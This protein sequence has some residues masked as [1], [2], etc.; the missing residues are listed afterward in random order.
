VLRWLLIGTILSTYCITSSYLSYRETGSPSHDKVSG[1]NNAM[2]VT[3]PAALM[4]IDNT[5]S[6]SES[7]TSKS[8]MHMP[9]F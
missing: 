4:L 7:D 6:C 9:Q 5:I 3:L 1:Y 8:N 2:N